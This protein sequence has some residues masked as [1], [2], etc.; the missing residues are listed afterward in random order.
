MRIGTAS[1]PDCVAQAGNQAE[2]DDDSRTEPLQSPATIILASQESGG[3]DAAGDTGG[4][5][6]LAAL[7]LS[8]MSPMSPM[9]QATVRSVSVGSTVPPAA[10]EALIQHGV[11]VSTPRHPSCAVVPRAEA[12]K[13]AAQTTAA[14]AG[15][16]PPGG[17]AAPFASPSMIEI[18]TARSTS[19]WVG[20]AQRSSV[21]ASIQWQQLPLVQQTPRS[22][23]SVLLA[24]P[25]GSL[26]SP[27]SPLRGAGSPQVIARATPV[28]Q[29]G[30]GLSSSS[31]RSQLGWAS[32][33]LPQQQQPVQQYAWHQ[34]QQMSS[35][36]QQQQISSSPMPRMAAPNM[37]GNLQNPQR[38]SGQRH[39]PSSTGDRS[40]VCSS[41]REAVS[42]RSESTSV[43]RPVRPG[44][45]RPL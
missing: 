23:Q 38:M 19:P 2:V 40:M 11:G 8:P 3:C 27:R 12:A 33:P 4:S 10:V 37:E 29:R 26:P 43:M 16:A 41:P 7:A 13:S 18:R 21:V 20:P 25:T 30:V 24:R 15:A 34:S 9:S 31:S 42:A 44:P 17:T 36:P 22:S 1:T 14:A 28:Q 6:T 35:S 39:R 45:S 5:G 32:G